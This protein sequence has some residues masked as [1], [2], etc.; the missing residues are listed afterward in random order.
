MSKPPIR[1]SL[2]AIPQTEGAADQAQALAVIE[3]NLLEG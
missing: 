2:Y 1:S 3:A